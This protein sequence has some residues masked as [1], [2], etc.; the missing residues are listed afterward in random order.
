MY[1][2]VVHVQSLQVRGVNLV[3]VTGCHSMKV[4]QVSPPLC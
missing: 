2:G 3:E 4:T 1:F